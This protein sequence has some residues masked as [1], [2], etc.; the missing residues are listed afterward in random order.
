MTAEPKTQPSSAK[1]QAR[2]FTRIVLLVLV[3]G[4]ASAIAWIGTSDAPQIW[5]MQRKSTAELEKITLQDSQSAWAAYVLG[6]RYIRSGRQPEAITMFERARRLA[7]DSF[8][9]R[10][11][12]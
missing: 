6:G 1:V 11:T 9:V 8:D 7:P 4:I 5:L 10:F 3:I 12:L 2:T